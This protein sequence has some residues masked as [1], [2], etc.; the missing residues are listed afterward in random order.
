MLPNPFSMLRPRLAGVLSVACIGALVLASTS[1][2]ANSGGTGPSDPSTG[3]KGH[4]AKLVHGKA[5]AP[6]SAD[7]WR[8]P[9]GM[10]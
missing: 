5:V 1:A 7:A 8:R 4:K 3:V 10:R 6:R 9:T 2:M